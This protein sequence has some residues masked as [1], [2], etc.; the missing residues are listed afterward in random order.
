MRTSTR[1]ILDVLWA[2]VDAWF[3]SQAYLDVLRSSWQSWQFQWHL[4]RPIDTVYIMCWVVMCGRVTVNCLV[5]NPLSFLHGVSQQ[6][7]NAVG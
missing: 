7:L 5:Q 6:G 2:S 1:L 4:S 3:H